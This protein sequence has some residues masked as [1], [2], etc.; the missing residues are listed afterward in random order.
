MG[1]VDH[2]ADSGVFIP[3]EA[4]TIIVK[5]NARLGRFDGRLGHEQ[6]VHGCYL[7]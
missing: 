1:A 7:C 3:M 4:F 2:E 5:I 6:H